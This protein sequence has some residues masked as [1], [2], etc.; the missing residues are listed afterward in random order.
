M[1]GVQL[2]DRIAAWLAKLEPRPAFAAEVAVVQA[3]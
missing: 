1:L 3:L 2:P